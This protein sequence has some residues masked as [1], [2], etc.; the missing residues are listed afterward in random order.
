MSRK[1]LELVSVPDGFAITSSTVRLGYEIRAKNAERE[2]KKQ[3]LSHGRNVQQ[4][5]AG[6]AALTTRLAANSN[7][8]R[9]TCLP[10]ERKKKLKKN[11]ASPGPLH[12]I[13]LNKK[14][15]N[16]FYTRYVQLNPRIYAD[17]TSSDS[18]KKKIIN[19]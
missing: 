4:G 17:T 12:A 6:G 3:L 5:V 1:V 9:P 15:R 7:G 8:R 16:A 2:K 13:N 11:P 19:I 14:K 10:Q 18:K